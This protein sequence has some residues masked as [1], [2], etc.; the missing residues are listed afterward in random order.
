MPMLT[1]DQNA[2]FTSLSCVFGK[3]GAR[4]CVIM[5]Q[6]RAVSD[7]GLRCAFHQ[8]EPHSLYRQGNLRMMI[9]SAVQWWQGNSE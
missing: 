7:R 4:W 1:Q 5:I 8:K 6:S 9:I 3:I 2:V